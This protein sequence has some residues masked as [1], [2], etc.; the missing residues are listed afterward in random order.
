MKT[1]TLLSFVTVLSAAGTLHAQTYPN[2]FVSL[3]VPYAAGGTAEV[4][5]R[6]L[7]NEMSKLLGQ[8]VVVELKPGAGGNIG[9]ELV[10]KS[11]KPDGYTLLFAS[12]SLATNVSLM[13]LNFDPRKD[14]VA[15]AGV[16]TFPNL[17][18]VGADAPV[19]SVSDLI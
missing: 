6:P 17:L 5:G 11:A 18:V 3:I 4:V 2:R 1:S 7:A 12:L 15:V 14:L 8:N 13:K 9:A 10:A 16:A 19:K